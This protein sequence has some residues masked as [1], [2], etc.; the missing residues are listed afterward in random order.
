M[1]IQVRACTSCKVIYTY[2]LEWIADQCR[3]RGFSLIHLFCQPSSSNSSL[4]LL[5]LLLFF[6][7]LNF[8]LLLRCSQICHCSRIWC[9]NL[10]FDLYQRVSKCLYLPTPFVDP[11]F[12]GLVKKIKRFVTLEDPDR[13]SGH[14][15][16]K[17]KH[18]GFC[19]VFFKRARMGI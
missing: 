14:R 3:G 9:K 15:A 16:T 4:L 5:L 6:F 18:V 11:I 13:I 8:N 7:S 12:N 17:K 19:F 10:I 2:D 1:H